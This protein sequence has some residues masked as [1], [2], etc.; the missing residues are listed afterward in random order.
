MNK[1]FVTKYDDLATSQ[2]ASGNLMNTDVACRSISVIP[3]DAPN[4]YAVSCKTD[5][6]FKHHREA[7]NIDEYIAL[8]SSYGWSNFDALSIEDESITTSF[9]VL[10]TDLTINTTTP[11]I[12]R[13]TNLS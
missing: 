8:R 10:V 2:L 7:I 13:N 4:Q 6:S 11:E 1:T 5:S 3:N 9:A 12:S